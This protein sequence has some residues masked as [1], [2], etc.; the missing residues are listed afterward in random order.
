MFK[1]KKKKGEKYPKL[2]GPPPLSGKIPTFFFFFFYPSLILFA[3]L[4]FKPPE[5]DK[6]CGSSVLSV[7]EAVRSDQD[8]QSALLLIDSFPVK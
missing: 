5:G 8:L 2:E 3:F 6:D 7:E 1:K 4:S